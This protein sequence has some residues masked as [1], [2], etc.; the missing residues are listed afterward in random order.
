MLTVPRLSSLWSAPF[1]AALFFGSVSCT[2]NEE[3]PCSCLDRALVQRSVL[4]QRD[5]LLRSAR[6][7][8]Q[9]F[10]EH[11]EE[12]V[13]ASRRMVA[14]H[15]FSCFSHSAFRTPD[16]HLSSCLL[17][18]CSVLSGDLFRLSLL[19]EA[20]LSYSIFPSLHPVIIVHLSSSALCRTCCYAHCSSSRR[21]C[22]ACTQFLR[23]LD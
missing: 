20:R 15:P 10:R 19:S 12:E 4:F 21:I 11:A 9:V 2:R 17:L 1:I 22:D 16:E 13:G 6:A 3:S 5:D 23:S 8:W 18:C 14:A 7:P